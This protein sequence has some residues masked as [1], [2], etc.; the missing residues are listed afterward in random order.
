MDLFNEE[1][2]IPKHDPGGKVR[3]ALKAG[4]KSTAVFGGSADC[5]RYRSHAHGTPSYLMSCS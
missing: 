4:V 5:Y 2:M 1:H 3:L